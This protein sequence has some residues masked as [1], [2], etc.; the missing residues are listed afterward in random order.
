MGR[1]NSTDEEPEMVLVP[2]RP[3][4][5]MLEATYWSATDEDAAGVWEDMIKVWLQQSKSGKSES[6]SG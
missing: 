5:E 3:T 1:L 4:E 6:G 2:R